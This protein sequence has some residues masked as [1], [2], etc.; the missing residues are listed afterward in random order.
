M[1]TI[2]SQLWNQRDERKRVFL[3]GRAYALHTGN[4]EFK[5]ITDDQG[6]ESGKGRGERGR[7]VVEQDEPG[8][9]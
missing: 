1:E 5:P 8:R 2:V 7:E 6:W 4:S 9:G 3:C